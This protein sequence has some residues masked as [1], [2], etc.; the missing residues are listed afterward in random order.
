MEQHNVNPTL[1]QQVENE[2]NQ[3]RLNLVEQIEHNARKH[4]EGKIDV[5]YSEVIIQQN[6]P[7]TE[8][9]EYSPQTGM[10]KTLAVLIVAATYFADMLFLHAVFDLYS[11]SFPA[12]WRTAIV[13]IGPGILTAVELGVNYLKGKAKVSA[14]RLQKRFTARLLLWNLIAVLVLLVPLYFGKSLIA[15]SEHVSESKTHLNR[16]MML[17]SFVGHLLILFAPGLYS[18]IMAFFRDLFRKGAKQLKDGVGRAA[19]N[20]KNGVS[21]RAEKHFENLWSKYINLI[22][23]KDNRDIPDGFSKRVQYLANEKF[24]SHLFPNLDPLYDPTAKK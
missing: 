4:Y 16:A 14:R 2:L 17:L 6:R 10:T 18:A 11:Q 23:Y 5:P 24:G 3:G 15:A 12:S 20:H 22:G 21:A 8:A 19:V 9:E 7:T 1:H 13:L